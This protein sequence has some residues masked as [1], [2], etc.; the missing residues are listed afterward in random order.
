VH[1]LR[2]AY[3]V[4]LT[5]A[6][7][8]SPRLAEPCTFALDEDP[9]PLT[10]WL[11]R[12]FERQITVQRDFSGGFPDDTQAPGPTLVSSATLDAVAGWFPGLTADDVRRRLR[13]NIEIG[14]VPAFW[15]DELYAGAGEVVAFRAGEAMLEG[16][17]PCARCIVP[18]RDP[19]TGVAI[20]GFA[21]VVAERRAATLPPWADRSRFDHYYRLAVN[22]RADP[23]QGGRV[24]A[25]GDVLT[26]T[27][28]KLTPAT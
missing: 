15:E 11:T 9:A 20:P 23:A 2:V 6:R 5:Q 14:G 1:E 7:F 4:E 21:K 25:V 24:I 28:S 19:V 26:T 18:S 13:A 16:T 8:V 27:S 22:T 3:D 10:E 17:N 12:H